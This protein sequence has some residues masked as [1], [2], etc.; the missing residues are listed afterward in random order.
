MHQEPA[1]ARQYQRVHDAQH[2]VDRVRV[3][4]LADAAAAGHRIPHG[5]EV[6]ALEV[7]L[8]TLAEHAHILVPGDGRRLDEV[9]VELDGG[10][11]RVAHEAR[12]AVLQ[13][14]HE[15]G[16]EARIA[17]AMPPTTMT[18]RWGSAPAASE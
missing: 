1:L 16:S 2:G 8:A 6:A 17:T 5:P 18:T 13:H 10:S 12:V 15:A 4:G 14:A 9:D 3:G 7:P 11:V